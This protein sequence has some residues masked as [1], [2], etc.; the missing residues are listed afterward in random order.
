MLLSLY[1]TIAERIRIGLVWAW[2]ALIVVF[3]IVPILVP[4]PLSFNSEPFFTFPLAGLSTRWYRTVLGP[5]D[6]RAGLEH[7]LLIAG[8]R[9]SA[10]RCS[11]LWRRS[12]CR[13][14]ASLRAGWS[15]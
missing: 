5:G 14:R 10:P 4:V 13:V 3:L 6:W 12:V 1:P 9:R 7:S 11:A 15:S 8:G 2:C